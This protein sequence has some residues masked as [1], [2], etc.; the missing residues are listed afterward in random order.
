MNTAIV[1]VTMFSIVI[2]SYWRIQERTTWAILISCGS[3]R[4]RGQ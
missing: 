4:S 2:F 3:E 1:A